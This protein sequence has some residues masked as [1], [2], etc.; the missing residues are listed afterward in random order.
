M[1]GA[2][3]KASIGTLILGRTGKKWVLSRRGWGTWLLLQD[4]ERAEILG[5]GPALISTGTGS[6]HTAEAKAGTGRM[7]H[8][9]WEE[10]RFETI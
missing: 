1:S 8:Q 7:N 10:I 2:S 3:R 6:G 9:L 5:D 4:M